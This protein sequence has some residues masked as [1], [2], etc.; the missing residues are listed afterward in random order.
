MLN[1]SHEL[2]FKNGMEFKVTMKRKSEG[3]GINVCKFSYRS[4]LPI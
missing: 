1:S 4:E 2:L 3:I